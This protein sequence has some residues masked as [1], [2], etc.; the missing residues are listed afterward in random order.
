MDQRGRPRLTL[1]SLPQDRLTIG[2][3]QATR[4]ILADTGVSKRL[5]LVNRESRDLGKNSVSRTVLGVPR[6]V[7]IGDALVHVQ[8]FYLVAGENGV[9]RLQLVTVHVN[10]HV[11]YGRDLSAALRRAM[12]PAGSN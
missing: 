5:D 2:P 7:P 12:R 3:T 10:G 11:G 1:V 8:P 6:L 9:P 4:R